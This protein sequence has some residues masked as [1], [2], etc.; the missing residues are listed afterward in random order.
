MHPNLRPLPKRKILRRQRLPTSRSSIVFILKMSKRARELVFPRDNLIAPSVR[1]RRGGSPS[2][3]PR[4]FQLLEFIGMNPA[5]DGE[6]V[7]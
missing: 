5:L 2:D 7:H 4:T 6:M 3:S 1:I